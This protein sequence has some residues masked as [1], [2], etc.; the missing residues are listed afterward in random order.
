[1]LPHGNRQSQ[2]ASARTCG[3]PLDA[4]IRAFV[5]QWPFVAAA[6][7][8]AAASS[9]AVATFL[10]LLPPPPL[11]LLRLQRRHA[12]VR[13]GAFSLRDAAAVRAAV[14]FT[15]GPRGAAGDLRR[16]PRPRG[17]TACVRTSV[18]PGSAAGATHLCVGPGF[19]AFVGGSGR[20][21]LLRSGCCKGGCLA[22]GAYPGLKS[23]R[24]GSCS[25]AGRL[26]QGLVR[27][28]MLQR[29]QGGQCSTRVRCV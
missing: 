21:V 28:L 26:N 9:H 8:A 13:R 4:A 22:T 27:E 16:S 2:T 19:D 18:G 1:M 11:P 15:A 24:T 29:Q 10:V 17:A 5:H 14:G 12:A 7:A 25:A 3:R 20:L 23:G 6:L